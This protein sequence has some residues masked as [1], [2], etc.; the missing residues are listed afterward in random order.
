VEGFYFA[1]GALAAWALIVTAIG[2]RSEDFP[3]SPG[4][5]RVVG[6]ISVVL[7]A[8]AIAAC[9]AAKPG[10]TLALPPPSSLPRST[11]SHVIV[12]VMENKEYSQVMKSS[13]SK[14]VRS[15]AK[16]YAA[17]SKMYAIRH[18]SL[19]NYIALIG[20]DTFGIRSDCTSCHVGASSLVD[21]LESARISWKGYMEGMPR[22]CFK[23]GE[24]NSYAK[25]HNP[26]MYFDRIR[27]NSGRCSHVVRFKQLETD[28]QKGQLPDFGFITPDLC[29]DTHDCSIG[30]GDRFLAHLVPALIHE[31]GAHGILFLTWDEG[32][33][34]RGCCKLAHGGHIATIV[35]G[36]DVIRGAR[37]S[38]SYT[39]Y[40]ILRTVENAFGLAPLRHAAGAR[41][42]DALFSRAPRDIQR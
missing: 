42:F 16:R 9:D 20:G 33:S 15:L 12:I 19:P 6:A 1:G 26:F 4:A 36:P 32:T 27:N 14:Y 28:L 21:Q 22:R 25:K 30:T 38:T 40:S 13:S 41:S 34:D 11:S 24:H 8:A 31:L 37:G 39:H 3:R 5:T 10:P 17:P 18:P 23:G 7:V 29:H 2:V 35:A